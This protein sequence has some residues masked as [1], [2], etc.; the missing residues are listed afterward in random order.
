MQRLNIRAVVVGSLVMLSVDILTS[1]FLF[2]FFGADSL[3]P[4]A[5]QDEI[6][7]VGKIIE[8]NDWYLL[9]GFLLG[10]FSTVLGGYVA[11]RITKILPLFNACAVGFVGIAA[12]I[13]LGSQGDSPWWFNALGYLSTIPAAIVGGYLARRELKQGQ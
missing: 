13:L 3:T 2:T 9:T 5:T 8:Q 4:G 11:A 12:A 7:A 10:T 1:I 6:A